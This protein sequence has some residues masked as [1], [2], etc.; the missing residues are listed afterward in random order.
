MPSSPSSSSSTPTF[1]ESAVVRRRL[2]GV[3]AVPLV[4]MLALAATLV[5]QLRDLLEA[6]DWVEHTDEIIA[7]ASRLERLCV[8]ME[9]GVRGYLLMH[10]RAF[11]APY[12]A[13]RPEVASLGAA[14][15]RLVADNPPQVERVRAVRSA[16]A[17]WL[18]EAEAALARREQPN[19]EVSRPAQRH[20]RDLFD[21]LRR[22]F[23]VIRAVETKLRDQRS[24]LARATARRAT[25]VTVV[26]AS[27]LGLFLAIA[28][29]RQ[30]GGVVAQYAGLLGAERE[31][32]RAL[33]E[34]QAA[35]RDLNA[36]LEEQ[37]QRRTA[38]LVTSN[39]ELESF[40]YSV[41]HDL[42]SPLRGIDGFAQVLLEDYADEV[43][44]E[45]R[46]HLERIR[47]GA[48]RMGQLIDDLLK[49][50]RV[51][52]APLVK[53]A[54][55]LGAVAAGIVERLRRADANRRVEVVITRPML[56]D[57]DGRLLEVALENLIGNAWKY[58]RDRPVAH[59]EIGLD[60]AARPVV[61]HVRDD[62]AGFDMAYVGKLFE[63]FQRL[64]TEAQFEG[65]GIGLATVQRV[66]QRH[67]GAVWATGETG[68]GATV[69]FTLAPSVAAI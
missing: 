54:V 10:D 42:R 47:A 65:T 15:E 2:V 22:D 29:A 68:R 5:T 60:P 44:A 59:I 43:D 36:G 39:R 37:V 25:R 40:C 32:A 9:T 13:G 17:A 4:L 6:T 24:S 35:L 19:W 64:H 26:A 7:T 66:V 67:G 48:R 50:S 16:I 41:S 18:P 31:R 69:F 52:R 12:D 11:L 46:R 30:L 45:G 38:E 51:T 27:L 63:P 55:D 3:L 34:T 57:G 14:L 20:A 23:D 56:G 8:D 49:L 21:A 28:G 33:A 62:G 58:T 61:Y 53:G 1:Q